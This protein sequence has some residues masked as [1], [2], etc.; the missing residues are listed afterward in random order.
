[1]QPDAEQRI[2]EVVRQI[3]DAGAVPLSERADLGEELAGHI[4]E[5]T[6]EYVAT[7]LAQD[8]ALERAIVD[9]GGAAT[10]GA[11]L[12]QTYHSRLWVSTIGLLLPVATAPSEMPG[13]VRWVARGGSFFAVLSALLGAYA[14]LTMSPARAVIVGG[15]LGLGAVVVWLAAEALRRG[16]SWGWTVMTWVLVVET[17][18]LF[19]STRTPGTTFNISING[20]IGFLLL[21]RLL[22]NGTTLRMWVGRSGELPRRLAVAIIAVMLAWGIAPFAGPLVADPTQA[23]GGDIE[24]VASVVCGLDESFNGPMKSLTVTLDITWARID[25]L[26]LGIAKVGEDWGDAV[27]LDFTDAWASGGPRLVDA[28]TGED[29]DQNGAYGLTVPASFT[30]ASFYDQ[31]TDA[32]VDASVM[33]PGRTVRLTLVAFPSSQ[34]DQIDQA[35]GDYPS[36][37]EIQYAHRDQFV[38][39]TR[40]ACGGHGRLIPERD[41]RSAESWDLLTG[42]P[43]AP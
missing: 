12:R 4:V 2:D 7:G 6:Q 41:L 32:G 43:I 31:P 28:L 9:F 34:P 35:V 10:I 30:T 37:V 1:V 22:A 24:V 20:L 36:E 39:A 13:V 3:L 8:T 27:K 42:A 5:R 14:A 15:S 25:P 17:V 21:I 33:R 40:L 11:E 19:S 29:L 38:L 16:Q 23:S 26:P 18:V